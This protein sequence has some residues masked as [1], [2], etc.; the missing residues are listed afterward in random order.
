[1]IGDLPVHGGHGDHDVNQRFMGGDLRHRCVS[2]LGKKMRLRLLAVRAPA[3]LNSAA[4]GM[5]TC[6]KKFGGR[7]SPQID[8]AAFAAAGSALVRGQGQI[9]LRCSALNEGK[10][11]FLT[12]ARADF[13]QPLQGRPGSGNIRA[14]RVQ[15]DIA[16]YESGIGAFAIGVNID[17]ASPFGAPPLPPSAPAPRSRQATR[18]RFVATRREVAAPVWLPL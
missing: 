2:S 4:Q 18:S 12:A 3:D 15:N 8:N 14:I 6:E 9:Y 11:V 16:L 5:S 17:T 1:M 13:Q 10:R 7:P